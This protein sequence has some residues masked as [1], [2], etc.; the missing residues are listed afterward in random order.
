MPRGGNAERQSPLWILMAAQT[1]RQQ[2]DFRSCHLI[3]HYQLDFEW[4]MMILAG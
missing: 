1:T 2:T 4:P 3:G